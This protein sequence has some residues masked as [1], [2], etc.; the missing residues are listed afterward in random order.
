MLFDEP[1]LFPERRSPTRMSTSGQP[2][3]KRAIM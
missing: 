3:Y 1:Q 2:S